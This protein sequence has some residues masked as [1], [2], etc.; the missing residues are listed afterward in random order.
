MVTCLFA[1][2]S[3][4]L[5]CH[6]VINFLGRK[7]AQIQNN[8]LSQWRNANPNGQSVIQIFRIGAKIW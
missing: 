3:I 2:L 7:V 8:D 5:N 1:H 6:D 4:D